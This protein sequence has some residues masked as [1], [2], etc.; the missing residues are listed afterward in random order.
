MRNRSLRFGI[1]RYLAAVALLP[2]LFVALP[3]ATSA[4]TIFVTTLDQFGGPTDCTL[5]GAIYASKLKSATYI[6]FY[7]TP[8]QSDNPVDSGTLK[9]QVLPSGCVAGSGNDT[10]VLPSG[11]TLVM[12]FPAADADNFLGRTAT[13]MITGSIVIEANG[14]TLSGTNSFVRAFAVGPNGSLTLRNAHITGFGATG[15]VGA[16]GGGGGM[17]AGGA[18]Y[19]SH[20]GHLTVEAC[21]FDGNSVR[22]GA[23]G[24]TAGNNFGGG[25]GGGLSGAGA[26][27]GL[28]GGEHLLPQGSLPEGLPLGGGGGG[29][30]SNAFSIGGGGTYSPAGDTPG[31]LFLYAGFNCGS[32]FGGATRC[33]GGGGGGALT[34]VVSDGISVN[35]GDGGYGGGGGGGDPYGG[36]G[37][38]GGFGGGGGGTTPALLPLARPPIDGTKGGF[39]GFGGGG[40]NAVGTTVPPGTPGAGGSFGG[41]GSQFYGGGGA[42]LG[43][44]IFA[45]SASVLIENS[46]FN[47]NSALGGLGGGPDASGTQPP[48]AAQNGQAAGGA[49]FVVGGLVTIS[50]STMSGNGSSGPGAGLAIA[51]PSTAMFLT[52]TNNIIAGNVIANASGETALPASDC[53]VVT[54]SASAALTD[55]AQA[56]LI[57]ANDRCPG[58]TVTG[59]PRLGPLQNNL[60]FTPTMAIGRGSAAFNAGDPHTSLAFDQRG[61]SRPSEGGFDVGAY[62]YCDPVR[63]P[64]CFVTSVAQAEPLTVIVSPPAGG[65]TTPG[66]GEIPEPQNTVVA[67]TATPSAGF[68]FQSWLGNV[69]APTSAATTVVMNQPQTITANFIACACAADVSSSVSVTRGGYVL[70]LGTKR[71]AQTVTLTNTSAT[72]IPGPISLV[73]DGLGSDVSLF[74]LT[75]LT[76]ALFPPTGDPY[77]SSSFG[78]APGQTVS[79]ALQFTDPTRATIGYTTR[80]LAGPGS[81]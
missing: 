25:G 10:I 78:L 2:L 75:G 31:S 73:L 61:V 79:I 47:N 74:N 39:G 37:G 57:Q 80:V 50:D 63:N 24:G 59:D 19:V 32:L 44:A 46:T 67:L 6:Q 4:N 55:V 23:G 77:I 14:A 81:R 70:N 66:A 42:G 45:E 28:S 53:S 48:R 35:G 15:G 72:P 64:N 36:S 30:S 12:K 52:I 69:T 68:V 65:T 56:N 8:G 51:L 43:G 71:Y 5:A 62:E 54:L 17:G 3:Q 21:T 58:A 34:L 38:S 60:G 18:I 20:D 76:D 40:G 13:P 22:G 9:A 49:I 26:F 1:G 7:F 29:S 27:A 41:N 11:A 33:P 16:A